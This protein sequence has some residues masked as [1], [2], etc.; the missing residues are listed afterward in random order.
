MKKA[1]VLALFC[2]LVQAGLAFA[3]SPATLSTGSQLSLTRRFDPP[4]VSTV[5]VDGDF[6]RYTSSA[7]YLDV[8]ASRT[9]CTLFIRPYIK[10]GRRGQIIRRVANL[11]PGTTFT[12]ME[13]AFFLRGSSPARDRISVEYVLSADR[14][15][16][17]AGYITLI[18]ESPRGQDAP[19][20][21]SQIQEA[22]GDLFEVRW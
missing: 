7:P 12:V 11:Q 15:L 14:E 17:G 10:H 8:P 20:S 16:D 19:P 6:T 2:A 4:A 5:F 18:C 21:V 22:L 13:P 1:F 3:S 9:Y